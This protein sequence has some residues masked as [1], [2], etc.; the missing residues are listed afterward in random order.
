MLLE[1]FARV[2]AATLG[3]VL[4]LLARPRIG[5]LVARV[6]GD[7]LAAD[8]VRISLAIMLALGTSELM[9]RLTFRRAAEEQPANLEPFR[10]PDPRLGWVFVPARAGRDKV[11][12]REIE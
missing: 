12:G 9:L 6:P 1:W 2:T 8:A 4:A 7:T 10:R 5:R 3:V 11:G